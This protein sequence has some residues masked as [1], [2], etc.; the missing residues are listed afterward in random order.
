MLKPQL[1]T[2]PTVIFDE[3][4]G[5]R[6]SRRLGL[7]AFDTRVE[8]FD[9]LPTLVIERFDRAGG[10]RIHQEDFNQVLGA[11]ANQKYQE[12]GGVVSL[13]RVAGALSQYAGSE[14]VL[15]L[16]QT[17]CERGGPSETV[18]HPPQASEASATAS[19]P[20]A[21]GRPSPAR[22]RGRETRRGARRLFVRS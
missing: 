12:L 14:D 9:G 2:R 3:E 7:A 4:Y 8:E 10:A 22:L 13:A 17:T 11:S 19:T 6:L 1:P 16:A 20:P 18:E 21:R 5:A 15:R